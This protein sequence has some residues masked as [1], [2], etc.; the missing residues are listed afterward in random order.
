MPFVPSTELLRSYQQTFSRANQDQR[1]TNTKNYKLEAN[2]S[3][4]APQRN[5]ASG[6]EERGKLLEEAIIVEDR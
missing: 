5:A 3:T 6:R 2:F 4:P 1:I